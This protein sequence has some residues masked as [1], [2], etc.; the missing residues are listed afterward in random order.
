[1]FHKNVYRLEYW[2]TMANN[3]NNNDD[4]NFNGA[5]GG[6]WE[7]INNFIPY[8]TGHVIAY[9]F[10]GLM[11]NHVSKRSY[12]EIDFYMSPDTGGHFGAASSIC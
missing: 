2:Y 10:F 5:T 1:M 12:K 3:S 11:L 8:F 9:P 4:S 6:I 7:R